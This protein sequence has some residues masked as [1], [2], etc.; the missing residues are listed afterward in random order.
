M[1]PG[2]PSKAAGGDLSSLNRDIIRSELRTPLFILI[3]VVPILVIASYFIARRFDDTVSYDR[4]IRLLQVY[5][6]STLRTQLNEETGMRGYTST[7]DKSFLDPYYKGL[8]R[9]QR[10]FAR[11]RDGVAA[12]HLSEAVPLVDAERSVNS[13]WLAAVARPLIADPRR[14]ARS[15]ALQRLGKSYVDRFRDADGGLQTILERA[16][17]RAGETSRGAITLTLVFGVV[18]LTGLTLAAMFFGFLG[19][20]ASRLAFESRIMYEN[21]KRIA[22]SLQEAFLQKA[23]PNATGVGL[24]ATYVP[25]SREAQVGGDWYDAFELPDRRILFSIGDVAGHGLDA[26]IVMNRAR[27]AIVSAALHEEDPASVLERANRSLILQDSRM[28]T[29]IC[30][31]LDPQTREIVYATAGHPAPV[32]A[33]PE[34]AAVFLPHDGL[35]LGILPEAK[36]VTFRERADAGAMLVLYTDGVLEHKRDLATGQARLLEAARRAV[37]VADPALAVE[38]YVFEGSEPTDDVAILAI[39]FRQVEG[40]G[41]VPSLSALQLNRWHGQVD[42]TGNADEDRAGQTA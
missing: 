14:S 20:R 29:A 19:A 3:A 38:S 37:G 10:A 42:V 15:L 2:H 16:A 22:D 40:D 23:L 26:A 8:S 34:A 5:R 31:Y 21:E 30:G 32:M 41:E 25:A 1:R 17:T 6:G 9:S 39:S 4:Q 18:A 13:Q 27:Q 12:A 36:Y 7:G 24:H 35:P 28:V 11:L 33:R